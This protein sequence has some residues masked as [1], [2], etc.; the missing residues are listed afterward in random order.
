MRVAGRTTKPQGRRFGDASIGG[1]EAA[2]GLRRRCDLRRASARILRRL[3]AAVHAHARS[4]VARTGTSRQPSASSSCR[5]HVRRRRL[6]LAAGPAVFGQRCRAAASVAGRSAFA[7]PG[8]FRRRRSRCRCKAGADHL[9]LCPRPRLRSSLFERQLG[10]AVADASVPLLAVVLGGTA[11]PSTVA[12]DGRPLLV[13]KYVGGNRR[14][15]AVPLCRGYRAPLD[16]AARFHVGN[17]V[18]RKRA[19]PQIPLPVRYV[20]VRYKKKNVAKGANLW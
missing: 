15:A 16:S 1:P 4:V 5:L 14:H 2:I 18:R 7:Q 17:P 13:R 10:F 6:R 20:Y 3:L 11:E 12:G 8:P 19:L 9:R